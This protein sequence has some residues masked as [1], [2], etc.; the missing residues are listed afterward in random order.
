M[1]S[2]PYILEALCALVLCALVVVI[3]FEV[4]LL[5]LALTI[6]SRTPVLRKLVAVETRPAM[7]VVA[8]RRT[9]A[10]WKRQKSTGELGV[11]RTG[12]TPLRESELTLTPERMDPLNLQPVGFQDH[13]NAEPEA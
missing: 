13:G 11:V 3:T 1:P 7:P 4:W 2:P 5:S 9:W 10:G 12:T 6:I 8:R